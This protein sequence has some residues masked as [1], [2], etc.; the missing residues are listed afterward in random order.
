V[1][2]GAVEGE[3]DRLEHAIQI[4]ENVIVP[5]PKHA[6]AALT[7]FRATAM[8]RILTEH[9]LVTIKLD[10]ELCLR[11]CKIDDARANGMLASKF[12]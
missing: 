5:E 3:A 7:Q 9:V 12:P 8:I 10:G 4:V 1:R 6:I 11:T 2:W